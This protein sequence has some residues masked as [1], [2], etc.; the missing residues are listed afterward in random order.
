MSAKAKCI[1]IHVLNK[2]LGIRRLIQ[3]S[4]SEMPGLQRMNLNDFCQLGVDPYVLGFFWC[5]YNTSGVDKHKTFS[6]HSW[7]QDD[8]LRGLGDRKA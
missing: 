8:V 5:L 2:Q 3:T 7:F 6:R 1:Q 4:N